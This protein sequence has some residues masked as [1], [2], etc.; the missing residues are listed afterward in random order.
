MGMKNILLIA[1]LSGFVIACSSSE[2]P[3]PDKDGDVGGGG[4]NT[5]LV[6]AETYFTNNLK[7]LIS[8]N[9]VSCHSNYHSGGSKNYSV[10]TNAK[11]AASG[12]YGQVNAGTMPKGA[13]K[14][15]QSDIDKFKEFLDLVNAIP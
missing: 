11:N 12:M 14:L 2:D 5:E 4:D 10:F 6:A 13:A 7:S 8:N 1:M 9:C 15:S 3:K